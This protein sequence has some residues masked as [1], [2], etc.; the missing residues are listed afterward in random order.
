[1]TIS[2]RSHG[3]GLKMGQNAEKVLVAGIDVQRDRYEIAVLGWAPIG[4]TSSYVGCL[5]RTLGPLSPR[6]VRP[7][8]P[9]PWLRQ[10]KG[11]AAN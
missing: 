5:F 1:M 11:R 8:A 9:R 3:R 7:T 6:S 10:R 2:A 4:C